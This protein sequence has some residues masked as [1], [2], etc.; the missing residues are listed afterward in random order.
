[1]ELFFP[2]LVLA[3]FHVTSPLPF[4]PAFPLFFPLLISPSL[5]L[6]P[7]IFYSFPFTFRSLPPFSFSLCIYSFQITS[8]LPFP[9]Y[10][11]LYPSIFI[12]SFSLPFSPHLQLSIPLFLYLLLL[13]PFPSLSQTLYRS[14][15]LLTPSLSFS[16]CSVPSS[17]P[18]LCLPVVLFYLTFSL[19]LPGSSPDTVCV[20]VFVYLYVCV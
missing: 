19:P 9:P 4:S 8:S 10:L 13:S 15:S 14:I 3:F 7:T 18:S 20:C 11:Q 16:S 5:S 1:M 2:F 12:Y 6:P 17:S